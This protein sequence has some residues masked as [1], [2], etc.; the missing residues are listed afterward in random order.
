[1]K[2]L[3]DFKRALTVGSKWECIHCPSGNN[4]GIREVAAIQSAS[5]GFHHGE[6]ISWLYFPKAK[7]V[8]F[9]D[10]WVLIYGTSTY[11]LGNEEKEDRRLLLKYRP[12]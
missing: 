2:T 6:N 12:V 11:Y 8:E 5:V 10:G 4:L 3:S 1:M 9:Q 7:E